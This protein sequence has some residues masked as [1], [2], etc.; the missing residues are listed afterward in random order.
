MRRSSLV[1]LSGIGCVVAGIALGYLAYLKQCEGMGCLGNRVA[2]LP[3]VL[4]L[5]LGVLLLIAGGILKKTSKRSS[6]I[7]KKQ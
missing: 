5:S 3:S 7:D 4:V 2:A 6:D 1:L